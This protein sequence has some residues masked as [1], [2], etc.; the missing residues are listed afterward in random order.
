MYFATELV[1]PFS[2]TT[3]Y[4]FFAYGGE[5]W[6]IQGKMAAVSQPY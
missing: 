4:S 2:K 5:Y 1:L 3:P 6:H